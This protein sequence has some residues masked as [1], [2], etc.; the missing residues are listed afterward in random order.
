MKLSELPRRQ[1]LLAQCAPIAAALDAAHGIRAHREAIDAAERAVADPE[2][3]FSARMLDEMRQRHGGSYFHFVLAYSL[4]HRR[5]FL[6]TPLPEAMEA[7]LDRMAQE[8]L[9]KQRAIEAA[10]KVSFEKYRQQYLSPNSLR[11]K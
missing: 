7:R 10:D 5:A 11:L 2:L 9:D 3:L 6:S 4:R 8:S 1:R